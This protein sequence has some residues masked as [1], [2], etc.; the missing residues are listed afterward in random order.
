M[1]FLLCLQF[2]IDAW[3][4]D[5]GDVDEVTRAE[6]VSNVQSS[7]NPD[8]VYAI[9]TD[10]A[11][12]LA[13]LTELKYEFDLILIDGSH[14]MLDVLHDAL[15]AFELLKP[16][17][18]LVFDDYGC[19]PWSPAYGRTKEGIDG[20]VKVHRDSLQDIFYY[21][22]SPV[23][24]VSFTK[25]V[26]VPVPPP[27]PLDSLKVLL[28]SVAHRHST[29]EAVA[30]PA[31]LNILVI[32]ENAEEIA[33][34]AVEEA[35]NL[36]A[37]IGTLEVVNRVGKNTTLIHA[38]TFIRS[39]PNLAPAVLRLPPADIS[40]SRYL[41]GRI[42]QFTRALPLVDI[43]F[44]SAS[45]NVDARQAMHNMMAAMYLLRVGG[46]L[47][48]DNAAQKDRYPPSIP[49]AEQ[50]W[51][52]YDTVLTSATGKLLD[53]SADEA[54]GNCT[55]YR[56]FRYL[57]NRFRFPN[58]EFNDSLNGPISMNKQLVTDV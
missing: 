6:F 49:E 38:G 39:H 45:A 42:S 48:I 20:F 30:P 4:T 23:Q 57:H 53:I 33:H 17:G 2:C 28:N 35:K 10:S 3:I 29:T 43:V 40:T 44:L 7:K 22:S 8:K 12:G 46:Y 41:A 18:T 25:T 14:L 1:R 21:P 56:V 36:G 52:G 34:W 27:R 19:N 50:A 51:Y 13:V 26:P 31:A 5:T 37:P 11:Y 55:T 58:S 54:F 47:V 32:A 16:G 15:L 24:V 9:P